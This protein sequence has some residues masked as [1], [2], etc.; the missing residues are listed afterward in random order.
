MTMTERR[1][2]ATTGAD[3]T[4]AQPGGPLPSAGAAGWLSTS[5]HKDVGR[6][7]VVTALAFLVLGAV[8]VALLAVERLQDD[9]QVLDGQ[10]FSQLSTLAPEAAVLL[11]LLP[12]F[13]GLATYLVP[14]QVGAPDIAFAR[15]SATAYWTYLIGGGTL[16]GAYAAGGGVGGFSD[17]GTDLYLLSLILLSVA[18]VAALLSVLTTVLTLRAPG[19]TM[20]RTPLFSWSVLVGGGVLLLVVPVFTA[21]LI[22]LFISQHFSGELGG[23]DAYRQIS[24]LWGVPTASLLVVP[25]AGVAAE[26]VPVLTRARLRH[27]HAGMVVLGALALLGFGAWA[28]VGDS[29]DGLLYVAVGL[30]A[31]LPALALL[32]ILGDTARRGRFAR[33]AALLLALGAVVHLVLGS[34]AGA[35]AVIPGLELRGTAWEAG[36]FSAIVLGTGVLGAYAALWYWGPKLWGV[37]LGEGAGMAAF[38]L[39]FWGALL[40]AVADLANGLLSDQALGATEFDGESLAPVLNGAAALGAVMVTLGAALVTGVVVAAWARHRGTRA[41]ADPWGGATL[42]WATTSPPPPRNFSAPL[43]PVRSPY[44]LTDVADETEATGP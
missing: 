2:G 31:V 15:G 22:E 5:D 18:T 17:V 4:A 34:L 38:F 12:C 24:W 9:L 42:E 20:L 26:V 21:R 29:L 6:L 44:P 43:P 19:M 36:H 32:G 13:L 11:F 25:A 10:R 27:H 37:H 14:L 16:L 7:Y 30:A 41:V 40:L 3:A 28:Q 23:P 39:G 35:L 33:K 8:G 1:P